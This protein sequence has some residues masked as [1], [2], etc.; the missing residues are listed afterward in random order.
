MI[1]DVRA[2]WYRKTRPAAE[3]APAELD[4]QSADRFVTERAVAGEL[5]DEGVALRS[6]AGA[7]EEVDGG[8]QRARTVR[9]ARRLGGEGVVP[10]VR[11]VRTRDLRLVVGQKLPQPPQHRD[12]VLVA[13]AFEQSAAADPA[14]FVTP[15]VAEGEILLGDGDDAELVARRAPVAARVDAPA[16]QQP[17]EAADG[18]AGP[19]EVDDRDGPRS[20]CEVARMQAERREVALQCPHRAERRGTLSQRD[21]CNGDPLA[22]ARAVEHAAQVVVQR[23]RRAAEEEEVAVAGGSEDGGAAFAQVVRERRVRR[24]GLDVDQ[25]AQL[26]RAR[27]VPAERDD[28]PS[29]HDNSGGERIGA[30]WMT[31]RVAGSAGSAELGELWECHGR[32]EHVAAAL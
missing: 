32:D 17:D 18:A 2:R 24:R 13:V 11:R 29:V 16:V 20:A 14:A 19:D 6:V 1:G 30:T 23:L 22:P 8:P 28:G 26:V 4:R 25:R 9:V 7:A 21:E 3:P 15:A 12:V 5:R 10:P 31:R 27:D